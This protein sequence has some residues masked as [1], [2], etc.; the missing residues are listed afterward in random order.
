MVKAQ[1]I[2]YWDCMDHLADSVVNWHWY[3]V[4]FGAILQ[5]NDYSNK[6]TWQSENQT[7]YL[8]TCFEISGQA[9]DLI[10]IPKVF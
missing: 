4:L 7:W 3:L 2:A 9:S 8:V 10:H 5:S 1:K 6:L